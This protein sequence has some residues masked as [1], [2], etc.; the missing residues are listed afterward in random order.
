MGAAGKPWGSGQGATE[1]AGGQVPY[2]L[3]LRSC[4]RDV[5]TACFRQEQ[6]MVAPSGNGPFADL[7]VTKT[8]NNLLGLNTKLRELGALFGEG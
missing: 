4:C 8:R 1:G 6:D 3:G 7:P 5:E 2:G